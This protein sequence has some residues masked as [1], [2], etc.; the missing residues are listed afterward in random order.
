[1]A[2]GDNS[3]CIFSRGTHTQHLALNVCCVAYSV[4][5]YKFNSLYF[6]LKVVFHPRLSCSETYRESDDQYYYKAFIL[7]SSYLP[8]ENVLFVFIF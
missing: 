2:V 1:M 6:I 8:E 5:R 7:L 3:F 4:P